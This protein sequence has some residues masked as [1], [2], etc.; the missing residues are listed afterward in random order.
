[1][2]WQMPAMFAPILG[3]SLPLLVHACTNMVFS[4]SATMEGTPLVAST[5]DSSHTDYRMA[6]IP[7]ADHPEGA[8]RPVYYSNG[9]YPRY[10]GIRSPVYDSVQGLDG[11]M[12]ELTKPIGYIPQV[13]HTF[14]Y[15]ESG[16]PIMN[17]KGVSFGES[18]GRGKIQALPRTLGGNS[19]FYVESLMQIALERCATARCAVETMGYWVEKEGFYGEDGDPSESGEIL[20]VAD[21]SEAWMFHVMADGHDSAVWVAQRVPE[22]HVA[23]AAN[24]F[25][26]RNVDFSDHA[27]RNFLFSKNILS[28][29]QELVTKGLSEAFCS[30]AET[31]DWLRCFGADLTKEWYNPG[32]GAQV[33]DP[34]YTTARM[35]RVQD[36]TAP[37]LGRKEPAA[38]P[39]DLPFSF[40]VDKPVTTEFVMNILRDK[41]KGTK[42]DLSEGAM[43]GPDGDPNRNEGAEGESEVPGIWPRAISLLRTSLGS[44]LQPRGIAWVVHHQAATSVFVPFFKNATACHPSYSRGSQQ[45]Y[46]EDSS[47]WT[48]AFVSNWM[49]L[50]WRSMNDTIVFPK[51]QK[52]QTKLLAEVASPS[53]VD[54]TA[55]QVKLQGEV[56]EEWKRLGRFLIFA[57]NN[58][59]SN[60]PKIAA[61]LGYPADWLR[62]IGF[63]HTLLPLRIQPDLGNDVVE[64]ADAVSPG[65]SSSLVPILGTLMLGAGLGVAATLAVTGRRS[66][67]PMAECHYKQLVA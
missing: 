44:V 47:W 66:R 27:G 55:L 43:A 18:T 62:S 15:W 9:L 5:V 28:T 60:Y 21:E 30:K 29:A 51:Q 8:L 57:Y 16:Y 25:A 13:P 12:Q 53:T 38:N 10:V 40:P 35:W 24:N 22:G 1:V 6:H 14:G 56:V 26:I 65:Q 58:G 45:E 59:Y 36:L 17:E 46:D 52:L 33:P 63:R 61:G 41:L 20:N 11:K 50:N 64:L 23:I 42:Y 19:L 39:F 2:V 31:F 7:A 37:S 3:L 54:L 4:K 32:Y 48:F 49:R 34:F 67:H